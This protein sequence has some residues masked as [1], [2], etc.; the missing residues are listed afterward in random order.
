MPNSNKRT[1][2]RQAVT[3][4][5]ETQKDL[6][7][8]W[9]SL[10]AGLFLWGS[11]AHLISRCAPFPCMKDNLTISERLDI[12]CEYD[13]VAQVMRQVGATYEEIRKVCALAILD[14]ESCAAP[15]F[16]N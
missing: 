16:N 5:I 15:I 6:P 8:S 12:L 14:A 3:L 2:G 7:G 11:R 13:E 1:K 4:V 10:T 9:P